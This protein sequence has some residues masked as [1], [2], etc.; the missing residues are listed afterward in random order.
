MVMPV[1]I[2]HYV[3][4]VLMQK[5]MGRFLKT[6]L[7]R[8]VL[9]WLP[10]WLYNSFF[11]A[12]HLISCLLYALSSCMPFPHFVNVRKDGNKHLSKNIRS[13]RAHK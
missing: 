7:E 10:V 3:N 13:F 9:C 11:S 6:V 5:L 12:I 8:V 1:G 2:I 4:V